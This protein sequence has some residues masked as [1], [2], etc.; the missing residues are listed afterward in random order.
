[1]RIM[2]N[3]GLLMCQEYY[4]CEYLKCKHFQW[5]DA[6]SSCQ[7]RQCQKTGLKVTCTATPREK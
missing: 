7:P 4:N 1:M 2:Y 6:R 3:Q 5:H